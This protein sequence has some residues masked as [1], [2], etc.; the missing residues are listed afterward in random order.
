MHQFLG[1]ILMQFEAD[2]SSEFRSV[3]LLL[4]ENVGSKMTMASILEHGITELSLVIVNDFL[5][6]C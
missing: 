4:M 5:N 2:S 6:N 1:V 3:R